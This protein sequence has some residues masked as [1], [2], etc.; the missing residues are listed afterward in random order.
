MITGPWQICLPY[1]SPVLEGI[2]VAVLPLY[3]S[4]FPVDGFSEVEDD[5]LLLPLIHT[6]NSMLHLSFGST[7]CLIM[8]K[9]A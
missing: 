9:A 8:S 3:Y 6:H 1:Y 7:V 5:H 4:T 2:Y